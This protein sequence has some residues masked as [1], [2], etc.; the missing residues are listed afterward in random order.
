MASV[1]KQVIV[2]VPVAEAW[3]AA[4]DYGAL[5][6]RLAPGFVVDTQVTAEPDAP[7]RRVTFANGVVL[8]EVIVAVD[9]EMRRIVWR[10]RSPDV[11]H[12]NGALELSAL[13]DGRTHVVWTADVLP[14]ALAEVYGPLMA[15]GLD[16]MKRTLERR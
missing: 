9:D 11:A 6:T 1:R 16:T 3:D 15:Q 8:D 10:I 7:V 13:D 12:H 14:D 4:R 5:H 2:D